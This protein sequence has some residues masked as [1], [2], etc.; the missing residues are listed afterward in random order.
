MGRPAPR[1]S[2]LGEPRCTASLQAPQST[3]ILGKLP[4]QPRPPLL[5]PAL[6]QRGLAPS[7]SQQVLLNLRSLLSA[8]LEVRRTKPALPGSFSSLFIRSSNAFPPLTFLGLSI[9]AASALPVV[10]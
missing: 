4:A 6:L 2:C 1:S 3:A 5:T 10:G 7:H 9:S 8:G